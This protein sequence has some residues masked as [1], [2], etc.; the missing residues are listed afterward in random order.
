MQNQSLLLKAS[1]DQSIKGSKDQRRCQKK[2]YKKLKLKLSM[3]SVKENQLSK[4]QRQIGV[5]KQA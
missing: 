2:C 1:I 4:G 3:K 5:K